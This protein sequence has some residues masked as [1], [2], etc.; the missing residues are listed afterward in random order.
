VA[1]TLP[2]LGYAE[3][4]LGRPAAALEHAL[5]ALEMAREQF[6][7]VAASLSE[8]EALRLEEIR[9]YGI[10]ALLRILS[11]SPLLDEP[12]A[13]R[14][15]WDQV[16]RSRALVLDDIARRKRAVS[17]SR[18]P[19][20]RTLAAALDEARAELAKLL[21]ASPT[22]DAES[23]RQRLHDAEERRARAEREL[24]AVSA[25]A[26]V[27]PVAAR[28]GFSSVAR[29]LPRSTALV[30]YTRYGRLAPAEGDEPPTLQPV[31]HY[32][33]FVLFGA[34]VEA[35]PLGPAEPLESAIRD[36]KGL[37]E[38]RPA[39]VPLA[40]QRAEADY[41][42]AA[43]RL[44]S[45]LWDP[46]SAALGEAREVFVVPDG[47]IHLV[48]FSTLVADDGTYF[49]EGGRG[50]HYLSTERDLAAK[51]E[52]GE[53]VGSGLFAL[54]GAEFGP[55]P[56]EPQPAEPA[57]CPG[58]AGL[59]FDPLDPS[60]VEAQEVADTWTAAARGDDGRTHVATG[61]AATET[62][63][64]TLAPG[65][66]VVHLAT[67][68]FFA[69]DLCAAPETVDPIEGISER[70][71]VRVLRDPL[72][73]SGLAFA[74]A[75]GSRTGDRPLDADGILTAEEVASLDLSR[76]QWIV[77]SACKTGLGELQGGEGVLGLRRAFETAGAR[78]LIMSLWA[79]DD[80][81]TR[82]WMRALYAHRLAGGSTIDSVQTATRQ[83]IDDRRR[84]GRSTHPFYWGAFVAAGDWL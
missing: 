51:R 84:T 50:F 71:A 76:V 24:A 3:L 5:A 30:A 20:T 54:G 23:Y 66:R 63:V 10:D 33:A 28:I 78:T 74:G 82:A 38:Q 2:Y 14:R 21:V 4:E 62:A 35:L 64:R 49:G 45:M 42:R 59:A 6:S 36:W 32:I 34:E 56:A 75:N 17:G 52:S 46:I 47:A 12:E 40:A 16:V 58:L 72:I 44:R 11:E 1:A 77:L 7:I 55:R 9:I 68:G 15:V 39:A 19:R 61:G 43:R 18:D 65:Y 26:A 25:D 69:Q 13:T 73:L 80:E 53:V 83:T 79:V 67:H 60:R 22:D 41:A 57:D 48:S 70:L 81:A 27:T 31:P 37:V 29:E 8:K